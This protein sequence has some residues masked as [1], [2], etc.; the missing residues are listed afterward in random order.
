MTVEV[1][2]RRKLARVDRRRVRRHESENRFYR[3]RH[4]VHEPAELVVG[5][6]VGRGMALELTARLVVIAP[7]REV[8]AIRQRREG[9]VE[10]NHL[11]A[12]RGKVELANDLGPEKT[13]DVGA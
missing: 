3:H 2:K 8:I 1:E 5:L 7:T 6:G 13:D 12:M 9:A 4:A 11:Q 10:R